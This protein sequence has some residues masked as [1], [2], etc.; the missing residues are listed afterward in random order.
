MIAIAQRAETRPAVPVFQ[1]AFFAPIP[2]PRAHQHKIYAPFLCH[3]AQTTTRPG[4]VFFQ[5]S[6]QVIGVT[7]VML[8]CVVRADSFAEM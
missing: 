2:F 6:G 3:F 8:C 7:D 4:P 1:L 5:P